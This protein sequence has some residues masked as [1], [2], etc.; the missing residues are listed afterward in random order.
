MSVVVVDV[1]QDGVMGGKGQKKRRVKAGA[2]LEK[3]REKE[4]GVDEVVF[5][6]QILGSAPH[7]ER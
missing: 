4:R 3:G 5:S 1:A 2:K 7:K 6:L